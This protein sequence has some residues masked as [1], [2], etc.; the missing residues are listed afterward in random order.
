MNKP[1]RKEPKSLAGMSMD[2]ALARLLQT[3]P[4]EL[5]DMYE[6]TR[7]AEAEAARF[8]EERG[9]SIEQG[10]RRAPKRFRP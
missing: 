8:I 9:H 2:E 4:K 3:N 5:E 6:Q 7:K 10:A 1:K